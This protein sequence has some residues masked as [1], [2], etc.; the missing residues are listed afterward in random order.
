MENNRQTHITLY[1]AI[2]KFDRV[3]QALIG[4]FANMTQEIKHLGDGKGVESFSICLKDGSEIKIDINTGKD[5]IEQHVHGMYN[6][7]AQV[8]CE[9][10]ELHQGVLNQIRVFNCVVGSTFE[11]DKNEDRTNFIINTMFAAANDFNGIVLMPD[12]RLFNGNGEVIFSTEGCG[13][14]EK[15][16]PMGNA[17]FI[18]T[19]AEE[20]QSDADRKGRSIAILAEKGIPYIPHL[21]AT[22][23]ES[24]ARIRSSKEIA[25]RL[26]A[27]FG[28][29]V[30][31][32]SR[33]SGQDWEE[34]QKYLRRIDEIL[35]GGLG[36]SLTP[37]ERAFLAVKAPDRADLAKFGWRYECCHVLMWALGIIDDLGYPDNICNVSSMGGFIWKQESLSGFLGGV[38]PRG[39]GEILDAADLVLRYDWACVDA[40]IKGGESPAGLNEEVVVEWHYALNWLIGANEDAGWDDIQ[41][42][43]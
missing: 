40:R 43:T 1:T 19:S 20:T 9:N 35:E 26:F 39:S 28:V 11:L 42:N 5:F 16:T 36:D 12:M 34:T 24:E 33:S 18:D 4:Q 25:R 37:D 2:G 23:M 14:F 22:V 38:K 13:D 31:C 29:C 32:E 3:K 10:R 27:M 17:D 8:K 6:F 30:Y 21:R 7:F 15:Y 41:V